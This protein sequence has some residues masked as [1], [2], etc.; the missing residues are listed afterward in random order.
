MQDIQV[1]TMIRSIFQELYLYEKDLLDREIVLALNKIDTDVHG[2]QIEYIQDKLANID[3][4]LY[5]MYSNCELA[6]FIATGLILQ[7]YSLIR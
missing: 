7:S 6:A 3:K 4:G 1:Q 5:Q 2:Q